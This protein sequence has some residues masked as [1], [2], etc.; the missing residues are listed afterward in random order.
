MA[1]S[2]EP[3]A[4]YEAQRR[5]HDIYKYF[6]GRF[7][8]DRNETEHLMQTLCWMLDLKQEDVAQAKLA[9]RGERGVQEL[10]LRADTMLK[11]AGNGKPDVIYNLEN[12]D[13]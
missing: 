5:L 1:S 7:G 4:G 6:S 9:G 13:G 8:L 10:I 3:N 2:V 12:N 11:A